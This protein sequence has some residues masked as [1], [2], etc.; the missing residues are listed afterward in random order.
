MFPNEIRNRSEDCYSRLVD[1]MSKGERPSSK[2]YRICAEMRKKE[3]ETCKDQAYNK[4]L[5]KTGENNKESV[6]RIEELFSKS[7][8]T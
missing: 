7:N 1:K 5:K 2:E 3:F 4:Y 8:K 6:K